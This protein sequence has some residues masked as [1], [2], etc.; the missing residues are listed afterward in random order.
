MPLNPYLTCTDTKELSSTYASF[1]RIWRSTEGADFASLIVIGTSWFACILYLSIEYLAFVESWTAARSV[2]PA[3]FATIFRFHTHCAANESTL[4]KISHT[5]V[6]STFEAMM[7]EVGGSG[8]LKD[9]AESSLIKNYSIYTL[10][11]PNM[12]L[13][14]SRTSTTS[15]PGKTTWKPSLAQAAM[16]EALQVDKWT[17][18]SK[19]KP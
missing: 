8:P 13:Y 16:M 15:R 12:W 4:L 7:Q 14:M 3:T 10:Y 18:K 9:Q 2:P 5:Q 1:F 6:S 17:S 11:N 19:T